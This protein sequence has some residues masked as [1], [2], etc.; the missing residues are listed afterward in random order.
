[1]DKIYLEVLVRFDLEGVMWPLKI[2]WE[3]DTVYVVD[4]VLSHERRAAFKAGGQGM[5]YTCKI[6]GKTAYLFF[7]EG[8]WFME[9]K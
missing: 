9:G 4:K 7:E 2:K 6:M 1:M 5:R 8:K 3:D